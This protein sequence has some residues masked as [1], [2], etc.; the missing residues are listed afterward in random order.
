MSAP[1]RP[2]TTDSVSTISRTV[3]VVRRHP[4]HPTDQ[5]VVVEHGL[6]GAYAGLASPR[7]W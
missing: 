2:P 1:T 5:A 3:A 7:R 4:Q 6:V